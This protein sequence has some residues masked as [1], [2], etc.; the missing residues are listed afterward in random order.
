MEENKEVQ[1]EA[2]SGSYVESPSGGAAVYEEKSKQSVN[3][4]M[5]I[6]GALIGVGIGMAAQVGVY[7]L[8]YISAICGFLMMFFALKGFSMLGRG[9]N[10]QGMLICIVLVLAGV[11][12]AY[13]ISIAVQICS[14]LEGYTFGDAYKSI[15]PLLDT[16]SEF[17][18]GYYEDLIKSYGFAVLS[19]VLEIVNIAKGR[20]KF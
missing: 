2:M 10:I 13:N 12:F 4:A 1:Q 11:Y 3:Y 15:S 20:R 14:E 17:K 19:V 6:L 9:M 7:Q 16:N 18:S 8:G 5:G